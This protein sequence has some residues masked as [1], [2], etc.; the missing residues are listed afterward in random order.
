[1]YQ[2]QKFYKNRAPIQQKI[3][4]GSMVIVRHRDDQ[5][6]KRA[7]VIDYNESRNKYK[8]QLID[9]G[10]KVICQSTELFEMEKSF[11]KLPAT[12]VCC[13]LGDHLIL[14]KSVDDIQVQVI[15]YLTKIEEVDCTV[16]S[17]DDEKITVD[18][19]INGNSLTDMLIQ[20]KSLSKLTKG[21]HFEVSLQH[22]SNNRV[23]LQIFH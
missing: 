19:S 10:I 16:L 1:M 21:I 8:V 14:N 18:V 7:N 2:I 3:P 4:I 13:K 11:T 12:A 20:D 22:F 23:I 9:F 6:Y 17:K 5:Q 15:K